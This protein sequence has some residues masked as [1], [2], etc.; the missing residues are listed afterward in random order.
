MRTKIK[1]I[2]DREDQ[3]KGLV[4]KEITIKGWVRTVRIQK[5]FTFIEVNDGSTLS[6]FQVV[7]DDTMEGYAEVIEHLS[8]GASVAVVGDIVES[9]GKNQA[10][11]MKAKNVDVIGRCDS[12]TYPLQKKRHSFEFLRTIAHLR[13]RTNTLG[14]ITRVHNTLS[15][16]TH[17][18]FQEKGFYY[19]HAPIITASDCE[20]AG[21]MF[22]VTTLNINEPPRGE[23]GEVDFEQ[24]F[25][26]K[27]AYLTVSGQLNAEIYAC[28]LSDVYTFGPTFRAENSHTSRH[29]AEF[30]MVEPEMSFA[31]IK[32]DMDCAE[33]YVRYLI[34]EVL[35][36]CKE[37]MIFFDKFIS[38]GI[39]ERLQSVV[40]TPFER[41]TYTE[42]ISLLEKA[43]KTFEYKPSWGEDLQSEHERYITEE[44]FK[45]PVI[46]YDY[47]KDIK[48]FYMRLNDDGKTVAAMDVL[49][50]G[51]G[52]IIG[53]SQREER[54][55]VLEQRLEEVGL[56]KENYWW[57]LEL[58]KYGSVP[59]AGFGL[60]FERFVQYVTGME[61]IRDVI[62]FPRTRGKAQF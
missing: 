6:N 24:D 36:K 30:W 55:D 48:A 33:E 8:T 39:L 43:T 45:K 60:G 5:T 23:E 49:V 41:I 62:S 44:V 18:F 50:P 26:D 12:E 42:A 31:D 53:G 9:P 15:A 47:P 56:D 25:F 10:V 13:P 16:A 28:A 54:L 2:K 20:G 46:V 32:D 14:A 11:E 59:H 29:L 17:R 1:E 27:P 19:I 37:D 4:G 35:D 3:G 61:N 51:V 38:K 22:Q 21:D 52:E 7:A 58:R 34:K 57:Y 40:D